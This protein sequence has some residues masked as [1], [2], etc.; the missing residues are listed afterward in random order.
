MTDPPVRILSRQMNGHLK[1][2]SPSVVMNQ[3]NRAII[4]RDRNCEVPNLM[5]ANWN[6]RYYVVSINIRSFQWPD[7]LL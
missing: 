5:A 1:R 7:F 4:V 3:T 6:Y 2:A